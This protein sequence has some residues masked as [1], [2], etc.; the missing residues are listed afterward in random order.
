M[1]RQ[2]WSQGSFCWLVARVA[3]GGVWRTTCPILMLFRWWQMVRLG[4]C[5]FVAD[6]GASTRSRK[7]EKLRPHHGAPLVCVVSIRWSIQIYT[8]PNFHPHTGV[9]SSNAFIASLMMVSTLS[10]SQTDY[11]GLGISS[12]TGEE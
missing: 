4:F 9:A 3:G 11:F 10:D 6:P 8:P 5:C 12:V 7:N 1:Q 2:E